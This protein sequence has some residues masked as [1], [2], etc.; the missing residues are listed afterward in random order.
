[1]SLVGRSRYF[2]KGKQDPL[3]IDPLALQA[4]KHCVYL[5]HPAIR[6]GAA[7]DEE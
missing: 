2:S 6:T 7:V 3:M 4:N 1:M 5:G